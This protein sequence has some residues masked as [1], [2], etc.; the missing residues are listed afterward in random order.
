MTTKTRRR[1]MDEFRANGSPGQ[2]KVYRLIDGHYG[3][4]LVLNLDAHALLTTP[5]LP[6]LSLF[7]ATLF[8]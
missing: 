3:Q 5:L 1:F 8:K 4:A 7:L 6:S 2:V